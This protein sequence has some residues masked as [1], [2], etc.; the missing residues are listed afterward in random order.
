MDTSLFV[1]KPYLRTIYI[2]RNTEGNID[3]KNSDKIKNL[4]D[5]S[6]FREPAS[7]L[8]V[9]DKFNDQTIIEN[10]THVDFKRKNLDN[11]RFVSK[12]SMPIVPEHLTAKQYVVET[13]SDVVHESS[14]LRLD[15]DE[16]LKLEEPDSLIPHSIPTSPET[17][18]EL[19]TTVY[20]AS[21]YE[22]SRNRRDSTSVFN[23]QDNEFDK[24]KL[25]HSDCTTFNKDPTT[26][27]EIAIYKNVDEH[28]GAGKILGSNQTLRNWPNI[29]EWNRGYENTK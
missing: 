28:L 22:N 26:D 17:I 13:F 20:G 11:V 3:M 21:L 23:H 15:P 9:D 4:L 25:T 10:T 27:N 19:P 24:D 14:F 5:P 7:G 2:E 29:S 16:K 12:I 1:Q 18:V 8:Y 6:N